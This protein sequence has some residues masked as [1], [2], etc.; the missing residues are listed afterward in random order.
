MVYRTFR[1]EWTKND[2]TSLIYRSS[3]MTFAEIYA[4][5]V[6]HTDQKSSCVEAGTASGIV[7][8]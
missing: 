1:E 5:A 2:S 7:L 3:S 4:E 6:C 8:L